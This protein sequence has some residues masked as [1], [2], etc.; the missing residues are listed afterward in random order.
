[1]ENQLLTGELLL[2]EGDQLIARVVRS[3]GSNLHEVETGEGQTFLA[4][5]P[6]KFRHTVWIRR[7]QFVLLEPIA[8]GD[9]VRAEIFHVSGQGRGSLVLY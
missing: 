3:R 6:T 2:P 1:M 4:S 5:I 7:G 9:K 8:E